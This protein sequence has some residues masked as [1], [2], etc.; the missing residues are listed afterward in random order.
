VA[1]S[2]RRLFKHL[3]G[4]TEVTIEG[5]LLRNLVY[6][7]RSEY[8]TSKYEGILTPRQSLIL[9]GLQIV[10]QIKGYRTSNGMMTAKDYDFLFQW[11]FQPIQGP[12]PLIQFRNHFP[13]TVGLLGRVISPSQGL[14]LNAGQHKHRINACTNIHALSEIQTHD[15]SVRASE[16]SSCL[17]PRGYRDRRKIMTATVQF[18]LHNRQLGR[19]SNLRPL[20]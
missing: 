10:S 17:R 9:C 14:Y 4:A 16:D 5:R 6:G 7:P 11:L 1:R 20:E 13:Q 3:P 15:P 18:S 12:R 19:E 8:R 2:S